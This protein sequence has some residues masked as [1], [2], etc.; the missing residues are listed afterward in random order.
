MKLILNSPVKSRFLKIP[1]LKKR[2]VC[3]FFK[4]ILFNC[5]FTLPGN[6]PFSPD[7]PE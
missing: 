3:I 6:D 5:I 2:R 7:R 1:I 4:T